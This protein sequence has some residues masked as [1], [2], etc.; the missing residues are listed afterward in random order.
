MLCLVFVF[1]S[2]TCQGIPNGDFE[3]RADGSHSNVGNYNACRN[4]TYISSERVQQFGV[5]CCIKEAQYSMGNF[6]KISES[7]TF[8]NLDDE[9][10]SYP[11]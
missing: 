9:I 8:D 3:C 6:S 4:S 5:D 10:V 7:I 1:T 2:V 11:C